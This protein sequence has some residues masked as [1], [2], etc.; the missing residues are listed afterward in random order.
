MLNLKWKKKKENFK[1]LCSSLS[2]TK[3]I[4]KPEL[5]MSVSVNVDNL[6]LCCTSQNVSVWWVKM[7]VCKW[8]KL[9]LK[10]EDPPTSQKTYKK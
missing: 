2:E 3:D 6:L 1:C 7:T 9:E 8:E 5:K 10:K 4:M